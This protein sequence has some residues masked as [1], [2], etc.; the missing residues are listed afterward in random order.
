M[1][2]ATVMETPAIPAPSIA[3]LGPR[4]LVIPDTDPDVR[5]SRGGIIIPDSVKEQSNI[6]AGRVAAM[7]PGMLKRDGSRWVMPECKVG[8]RILYNKN[9]T[10]IVIIDEVKYVS[11][12]D[13]NVLCAAEEDVDI[14]E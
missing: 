10:R 12:Y 6:R 14:R 1:S 4:L 3:L 7:G 2:S 11:M 8:E 13:D 9:G 5:R